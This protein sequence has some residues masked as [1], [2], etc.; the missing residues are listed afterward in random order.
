MVGFS[1][2]LSLDSLTI[3]NLAKKTRRKNS[4]TTKIRF[5]DFSM[6][7]AIRR[8]R[9]QE[10]E[11]EDEAYSSDSSFEY[12]STTTRVETIANGSTS[13][14][15]ST[16]DYNRRP[17]PIHQT[18]VPRV[19]CAILASIT[20][21]GTT[22]AFGLYGGALKKRLQLTQ[23]QLDTISAVFFSAGLLSFIPGAMVDRFGARNGICVG[24]ITG[25]VSLMM[26]WAVAKGH[27]PYFSSSSENGDPTFIVAVLSTLNV[28]IFLSCALVTGSV[29]KIISC[30][31]GPGSKGSAVGVA[32]GFVGLGSGAYACLFQSLRQPNMSELDFLP[33]CAFFFIAAA[34]I[35][36][37]VGLPSKANEAFVP[38]VLTPLHFRIM[39]TSLSLLAILIIGNALLGLYNDSFIISEESNIDESSPNYIMAGLLL[40]VWIAPI[41]SLLCLPQRSDWEPEDTTIDTLVNGGQV[42]H[43]DAGYEQ[44][45]LLDE[46]ND[47]ISSDQSNEEGSNIGDISLEPITIQHQESLPDDELVVN[48]VRSEAGDR[49]RADLQSSVYASSIGVR[50]DKNLFQMLRTPSAWMMLWTA[51]I[52]AGG[53]TVETNNL[54]QMVESLG[55]SNVVTHATLALFSVAQSGGR[56]ITGA[57]SEAALTFET[58]RCCIDKGVPRP[59]FFV[60]ASL[61]AILAHT[62]LAVATDQVSFVIG[63]TLSGVAFGMIWPL[64]VLCVGE[65]FGTAHVGA[66]YMFYDGFTSAVGTF[67]LS[68]VCAQKVYEEHIDAS[69]GVT[70]YGK[71]CFQQTHI[72]IVFLSMT[73]VAVS[74]LMQFKT[75]NVYSNTNL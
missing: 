53:G 13:L 48:E 43:D 74:L 52:L 29:F 69:D 44:V 38:D 71:E 36:S 19:A 54:G 57:A 24:G 8:Q 62:I 45:T 14:D 10:S 17:L 15:V 73:C 31:C 61:A 20:T 30:E 47:V 42:D 22:Y 16:S 63:I 34:S 28:G 12:S 18:N 56:I 58:S 32:K 33:L 55:F 4:N 75:R 21:G 27:F 25:A 41:A 68:K 26:F 2:H 51:T 5:A 66:N 11:A 46:S 7:R 72:I 23:S 9:R 64:M 50:R 37:W 59:F 39:Y 35:P 40:F 60:A 6:T 49:M 1:I 67:M 3:T 70:C 65:L